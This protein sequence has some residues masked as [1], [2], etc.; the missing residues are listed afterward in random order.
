MFLVLEIKT[1]SR[2]DMNGDGFPL[3]PKISLRRG[4]QGL[5]K[6]DSIVDRLGRIGGSTLNPGFIT[7]S[8][9]RKQPKSYDVKWNLGFFT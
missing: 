8:P 5:I 1:K 9:I 2:I 3:K 4:Q 7:G 6:Y